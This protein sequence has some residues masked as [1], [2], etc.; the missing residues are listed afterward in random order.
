MYVRCLTL[1]I[2]LMAVVALGLAPA[3]A[4]WVASDDLMANELSGTPTNSYGAWTL[5]QTPTVGG[6]F[7]AF[8][9]NF[10]VYGGSTLAG[11]GN[12]TDYYGCP[13]IVVNVGDSPDP[14]WTDPATPTQP[15]H[16]FAHPN[17]DTACAVARWTAPASGLYSV[18]A[19]WNDVSGAMPYVEGQY[20]MRTYNPGVDVHLLINGVSVFNGVTDMDAATG[21]ATLATTLYSLTAG[22][23]LDFVI[24]PLGATSEVVASGYSNVCDSTDFDATITAVP[25]PGTFVLLGSAL[26][27]LLVY[28][29]RRR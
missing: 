24:S 17:A 28:A 15:G 2:V 29:W 10:G 25:E 27:G 22:D 1:T 4:A 18:S 5:G 13:K 14:Y 3:Q 6:E 26:C 21:P 19:F 8:T 11:W 20:D 12:D 9:G 16:I 7:A 23:T